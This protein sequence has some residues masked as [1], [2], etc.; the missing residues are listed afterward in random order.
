[1]CCLVCVCKRLVF[2]SRMAAGRGLV[3]AGAIPCLWSSSCGT[4]LCPPMAGVALECCSRVPASASP[5][6]RCF[7]IGS[8]LTRR[9]MMGAVEVLATHSC[10]VAPG[11]RRVR[12]QSVRR[13]KRSG[14]RSRP[15]GTD[16]EA[17]KGGRKGEADSA[18]GMRSR[19]S[20][21]SQRLNVSCPLDLC[22]CSCESSRSVVVGQKHGR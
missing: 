10:L 11:G 6:T 5:R 18:D 15:V 20:F 13:P 16:A 7:L 17:P 21:R 12:V 22:C 19:P 4:S 2:A 8:V 1:M 3:A 14:A 9:Q